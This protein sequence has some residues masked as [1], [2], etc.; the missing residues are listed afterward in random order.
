MLAVQ[1]VNRLS[2]APFIWTL[3]GSGKAISWDTTLQCWSW[4]EHLRH[5]EWGSLTVC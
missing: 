5:L 4:F 3:P 1:H 2:L